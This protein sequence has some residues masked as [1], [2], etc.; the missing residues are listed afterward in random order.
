MISSLWATAAQ[1][2]DALAGAAVAATG[3]GKPKRLKLL[4]LGLP[5]AGKTTLLHRMRNPDPTA[6][7]SLSLS[8]DIHLDVDNRQFVLNTIDLGGFQYRDYPGGNRSLWRVC[9]TAGD[10]D[11]VV[12]VVDAADHERLRHAASFFGDLLRMLDETNGQQTTPVLV[13]GNKIDHHG[14]L[15]EEELREAMRLRQRGG[16][17]Q[18]GWRRQGNAQQRPVDLFMCSAIMGQGYHQGFEWLARHI[19]T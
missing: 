16:D 19:G 5:D 4:I 18:T 13:L 14:A 11:G 15:A 3:I 6:P 17:G 8:S 1:A 2:F 12:L 10:V 7:A 9:F